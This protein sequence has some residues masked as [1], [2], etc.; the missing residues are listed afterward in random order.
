MKST[1]NKALMMNNYG[2]GHGSYGKS[3]NHQPPFGQG[4]SSVQNNSA[5]NNNQINPNFRFSHK[6]GN[7][8]H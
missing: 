6:C 2:R 5:P 3:Y 7:E 8:E 4:G 1:M